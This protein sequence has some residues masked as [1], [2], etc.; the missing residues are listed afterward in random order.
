MIG[1]RE[2]AIWT[3]RHDC[4][5]SPDKWVVCLHDD[6]TPTA[7]CDT[8]AAARAMLPTNLYRATVRD[9]HD[10]TLIELWT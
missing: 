1:W 3:I 4:S 8:L 5:V 6:P 10:D 7:V 9:D 2:D